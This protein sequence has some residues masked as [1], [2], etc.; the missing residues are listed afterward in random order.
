MP[1]I[2]TCAIRYTTSA[3]EECPPARPRPPAS[4]CQTCA[5]AP[6]GQ[7]WGSQLIVPCRTVIQGCRISWPPWLDLGSQGGHHPAV[8]T[9]SIRA[10]MASTV[11]GRPYSETGPEQCSRMP[12][13]RG[14]SGHGGLHSHHIISPAPQAGLR[15]TSKRKPIAPLPTPAWPRC[16]P[17]PSYALRPAA[18]PSIHSRMLHAHDATNHCATSHTEGTTLASARALRELRAT[19]QSAPPDHHLL[20][21]AGTATHQRSG[22]RATAPTRT[23]SRANLTTPLCNSSCI[24]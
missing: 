5:A 12:C 8:S 6:V 1:L 7:L 23:D 11:A 24:P 10:P 20:L 3:Y 17:T 14:S 16:Q 18:A 19:L 22:S 9:A 21:R 2:R 15:A 4:T 13:G